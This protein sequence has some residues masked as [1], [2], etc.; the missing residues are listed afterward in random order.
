[1]NAPIDS[2]EVAGIRGKRTGRGK[3]LLVEDPSVADFLET[4]LSSSGYDTTACHTIDEAKGLLES[5]KFDVV[6][7]GVRMADGDG[8]DFISHVQSIDGRTRIIALTDL[9]ISEIIRRAMD[10]GAFDCLPKP[11]DPLVL[12]FKIEH[13]LHSRNI[14]KNFHTLSWSIYRLE[15]KLNQFYRFVDELD[16]INR[17]CLG[18]SGMDPFIYPKEVLGYATRIVSEITHTEDIYNT[19]IDLSGID[20]SL[21]GETVDFD[22]DGESDTRNTGQIN[23]RIFKDFVPCIL[24]IM[25][26]SKSNLNLRN[27]Y[28]NLLVI[29][30]EQMESRSPY[31]SGHSSRVAEVSRRIARQIGMVSEN[32]ELIQESSYIHDLGNLM[33]DEKVFLKKRINKKE[34]SEIQRHPIY[35]EN[36]VGDIRFFQVHK[37]IVR[38]HHERY[39]GRGYP[40]GIREEE[41]PKLVARD[42]HELAQGI[43][44]GNALNFLELYPRCSLLRTESRGSHWREDYPERD[45]ANWLKWV[46]AKREDDGIRVWAEPIPYDEYPLKPKLTK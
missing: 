4:C 46:I 29:L 19:F 13:A 35:C 27:N 20:G 33:I 18:Q 22:P 24:D 12:R 41:I 38:S 14:D 21:L 5:R 16:E 42:Y 45:D 32:V 7:T 10:R 1:M 43:G 11:L 15:E 37:R 31:L 6:L 36:I 25:H 39:D 23:S 17:K 2:E 8:L 26:I 40:D 34:Y 28:R 30:V 44:L 3:I 9:Y